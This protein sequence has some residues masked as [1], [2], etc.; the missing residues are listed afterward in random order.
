MDSREGVVILGKEGV[1]FLAEWKAIAT[2]LGGPVSGRVLLTRRPLAD[3]D[4]S[5]TGVSRWLW[6]EC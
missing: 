6:N 3:V 2:A 5:E 1:L 4:S